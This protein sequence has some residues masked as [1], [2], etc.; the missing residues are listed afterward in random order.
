MILRFDILCCILHIHNCPHTQSAN[1]LVPVLSP[2]REAWR[3]PL[4]SLVP[5]GARCPQWWLKGESGRPCADAGCR[6]LV[7]APL[8]RPGSLRS[9]LRILIMNGCDTEMLLMCFETLIISS[10]ILLIQWVAFMFKLHTN[11]AIRE[12]TAPRR[13]IRQPVPALPTPSPWLRGAAPWLSLCLR[14]L[15]RLWANSFSRR[16]SPDGENL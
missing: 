8:R 11:P 14:T 1:R 12:Q 5:H 6:V 13:G 9:F 3:C 10:F 4:Y 2:S 16:E 7:G 15:L